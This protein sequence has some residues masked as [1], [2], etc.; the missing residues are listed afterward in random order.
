MELPANAV[1]F[2]LDVESVGK[3]GEDFVF[4][5]GGRGQHE[6][7]RTEEA[8][9]DLVELAAFGKNR[10]FADVPEDHVGAADGF[11]GSIERACDGFFDGVFFQTDA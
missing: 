5:V 4:R 10:G 11:D 1:V 8:E 2:V 3:R 6:L 7:H 9:R